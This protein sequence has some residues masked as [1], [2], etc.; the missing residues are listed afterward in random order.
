[1]ALGGQRPSSAWGDYDNDGDL[2]III[3][4]PNRQTPLTKLYQNNYETID[5][6]F[7]EIWSPGE[8]LRPLIIKD[9]M[10]DE[11]VP[12]TRNKIVAG[13]LNNLEIMDKRGTGFL[14]MREDMAKWNLPNP[15]I[16]EKQGWFVIRLKNP[17]VEK[18]S[19][20]CKN[21]LNERQKKAIEHIKIKG[22]ITNKEYQDIC[23][24]NR[25]MAFRDLS[26]LVRKNIIEKIGK[27][28]RWTYY[29]M[30]R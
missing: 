28:G 14:R 9:I 23:K 7:V 29:M 2:D 24:V 1:M 8:L 15:E 11:Y 3:C 22:K 27:T 12:E 4:G 16:E 13:V 30:K 10:E 20:I 25:I 21:G 5:N 19:K 17:N 18:I 26:E 6:S